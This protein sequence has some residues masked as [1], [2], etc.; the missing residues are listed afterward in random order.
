MNRHCA[1]RWKTRPTSVRQRGERPGEMMQ[2]RQRGGESC[3]ETKNKAKKALFF[4]CKSNGEDPG[5]FGALRISLGLIKQMLVKEKKHISYLL[6]PCLC[7]RLVQSW[8][9]RCL[10]SPPL[11]CLQNKQH[12][13]MKQRLMQ[14]NIV[15]ISRFNMYFVE[16]YLS[17]LIIH[18]RIFIIGYNMYIYIYIMYI[19][20][21][22]KCNLTT[23]NIIL[24]AQFLEA[25]LKLEKHSERAEL[26]QTGTW[27]ER[28]IWFLLL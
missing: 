13:E 26:R 15:Y 5:S 4:P 7:L 10:S 8:W 28:Q 6:S 24:S 16:S 22:I 27:T 19:F 17:H 1:A 18:M 12:L 9:R 3:N 21:I 25:Y 23:E 20:K 2:L 14:A 11:S